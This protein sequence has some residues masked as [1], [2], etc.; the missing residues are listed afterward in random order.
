LR[1]GRHRGVVPDRR[2]RDGLI[3]CFLG[4]EASL[5][6]PAPHSKNALLTINCARLTVSI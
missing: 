5:F 1:T 3:A 4:R 2:R 6:S